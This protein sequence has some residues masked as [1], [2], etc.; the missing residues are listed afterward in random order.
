M[1][2]KAKKT[3]TQYE[4]WKVIDTSTGIK[5]SN[6]RIQALQDLHQSGASLKEI[7]LLRANLG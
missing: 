4:A 6:A 2:V 3:K 1:G 5:T 7:D